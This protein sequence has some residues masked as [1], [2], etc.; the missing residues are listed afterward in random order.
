MALTHQRL[1]VRAVLNMD[2]IHTTGVEN[3][4]GAHV[5]RAPHTQ[6]AA[7]SLC[8]CMQAWPEEC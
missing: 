3:T 4:G 7:A 8:P 1:P 5:R 6:T 2:N